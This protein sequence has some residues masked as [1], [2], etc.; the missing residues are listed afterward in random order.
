MQ[1]DAQRTPTHTH[2]VHTPVAAAA[3]AGREQ[4]AGGSTDGQTDIID[5][6]IRGATG[7]GS[8]F[9]SALKKG[10]RDP[11]P[12]RDQGLAALFINPGY[13]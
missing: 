9:T 7:L 12:A 3:A 6:R 10:L 8:G 4:V 1:I 13:R 11:L 5:V 2:R